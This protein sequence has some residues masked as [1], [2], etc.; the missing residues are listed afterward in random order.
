MRISR[1]DKTVGFLKTNLKVVATT[2]PDIIPRHQLK[3]SVDE[4]YEEGDEKSLA[5]LTSIK[6]DMD[7][8]FS[9]FLKD[10]G[11]VRS[12]I[13][14][15]L[16]MV[17]NKRTDASVTEYLI[18]GNSHVDKSVNARDCM[19][20]SCGTNSVETRVDVDDKINGVFLD[21]ARR[22]KDQL[23]KYK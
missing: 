20:M 16:S 22:L 3:R 17:C 18:E 1:I 14:Q 10:G 15:T 23:A 11:I 19:M 21:L 8:D 6:H 13:Q 5:K 9:F 4:I 7:S 2:T 12:E